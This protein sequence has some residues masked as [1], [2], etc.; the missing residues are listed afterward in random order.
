M[1]IFV[2][3]ATGAI[4][5][6]LVPMLV[7]KG[8]EVYGLTRTPSKAAWLQ[9]AGAEPI[10][11]DALDAPAIQRAL[12]SVRPEIV[13]HQLTSIASA[14]D[15]RRFDEAFAASNRLRTE[16]LKILIA[17]A[18][19]AKARKVIAQSFCGWPYARVGGAVKTEDDPLDTRP[20]RRQIR[21]LAAI[22]QLEATVSS[23]VDL[24]GIVLR[25]GTFYGQDTGLFEPGMVRMLR[26]GMLPLIGD[27]GGWWSFVHV[28]D[29]ASATARAVEQTSRGVFN[30]VDSD[31]A[32]AR[33]W[34]PLAA[35][36]VGGKPPPS[37]PAWLARLVAG[38]HI[39]AMMTRARAGSNAKIGREWG[40]SPR[41]PSWRTGFKEVAATLQPR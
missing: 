18:R 2:A 24:E 25:Y 14:S 6:S 37:V 38:E 17:A 12:A 13:I 32:P 27:G 21:T 40:W 15:V 4:G 33:Q 36:A 30:V 29:A 11:A 19:L 10:V 34:L 8:G 16:G 20:A 23:L 26:R 7:A 9:E 35:A 22:K 5:R 41:Y 3:G 28:D 1:R 31:P 39:V